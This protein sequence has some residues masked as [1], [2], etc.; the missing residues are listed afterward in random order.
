MRVNRPGEP[1]F[2]G[3]GTFCKLPLVL[4]PEQL[5]GVDVAIVGAPID[6]TVSHRPGTRFGPRAV[7]IAEDSGGSPPSRPHM[8]LGIDPFDVLN[9]V[10]YGDAETIAAD[11]A[12]SHRAIKQRV[13]EVCAAGAVPV[14]LGGDHSIAHPNITAIAEHHGAGTVGVIHFDAHADTATDLRGVVL[15]HGTPMRRVVDEGS[16]RGDMFIQLGLRGCWPGSEEFSWMRGAGFRWYTMY[17]LDERGFR[18]CIDEVLEA[19]RGWDK[20]FL[21][22]DID[23]L[24]PAYAPGTGT[25]EPGGLTPRELLHA[26]RRIGAELPV[27]GMELVEVAPVWDSHG[28]VTAINGHRV[29][30]DALCGM[31]LRRSGRAA[32]PELDGRVRS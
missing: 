17:E 5:E 22:V 15:S 14:L 2:A 25:P 16:V 20:V 3:L 28:N 32:Q 31:A 7:R 19:A 18:R 9:V 8:L 26:V 6:D 13:A 4:E 11:P 29:V 30:L 12:R 1:G 23:S 10:D 21:S 27:V 24:D